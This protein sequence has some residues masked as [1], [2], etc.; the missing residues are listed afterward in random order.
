M[1]WSQQF[2]D[3]EYWQ[4]NTFERIKNDLLSVK[5][6]R[7]V[8]YGGS[9]EKYLVMVYGKSQVGKSTMILSMIGIDD[10]F[11]Q[12]VYDTLR[13]GIPRGNSS[14]STAIIGSVK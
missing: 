11:F 5:G 1:E 12:E 4:R 9:K 14:T 3:K 13:A 6:N 7:F 2:L 8:Q 10:R